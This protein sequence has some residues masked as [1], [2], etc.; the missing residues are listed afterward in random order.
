M[1]P[2][3]VEWMATWILSIL[4]WRVHRP[5]DEGWSAHRSMLVLVLRPLA[6]KTRIVYVLWT[7]ENEFETK[8][9]SVY[10][11]MWQRQSDIP[12]ILTSSPPYD[13][14][15]RWWRKISLSLRVRFFF[16]LLL[17]SF[18]RSL[19]HVQNFYPS[20]DLS[21]LSHADVYY[22]YVFTMLAQRWP[23][24]IWISIAP[25]KQQSSSAPASPVPSP[26]KSSGVSVQFQHLSMN[27]VSSTSLLIATIF[28]ASVRCVNFRRN[29]TEQ[30]STSI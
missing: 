5:S 17:S 10:K 11:S 9:A 4:F 23:N 2:Q 8:S 3:G 13:V 14:Y 20:A 28:R 30:L 1:A 18:C 19:F 6:W 27:N 25:I 16:L 29:W 26:S 15:A 22:T 24:R 7:D 12:T 21:H